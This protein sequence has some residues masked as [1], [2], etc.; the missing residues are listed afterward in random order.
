MEF[1]ELK[2]EAEA[3]NSN[4]VTSNLNTL[5]NIIISIFTFPISD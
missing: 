2:M 4:L 1:N 3:P 5:L